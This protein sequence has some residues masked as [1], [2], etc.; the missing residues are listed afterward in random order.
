LWFT[1]EIDEALEW[2]QWTHTVTEHGWVRAALPR[3]GGLA[4]QDALLMSL[5]DAMRATANA[6]FAERRAQ[7][8]RSHDLESWRAERARARR[9][10]A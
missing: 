6:L 5:L 9:G 1:P 3:A 7:Q 2:F 4:E 8:A 10:S